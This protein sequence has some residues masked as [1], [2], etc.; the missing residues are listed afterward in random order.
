MLWLIWIAIML[1]TPILAGL[2]VWWE[3]RS[4]AE[5]LASDISSEQIQA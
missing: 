1:V 2:N 5:V 3:T 4:T